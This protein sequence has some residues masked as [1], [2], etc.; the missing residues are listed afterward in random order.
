[1][2]TG[3]SHYVLPWEVSQNFNILICSHTWADLI[4]LS[5]YNNTKSIINVGLGQGKTAYAP[6]FLN[7]KIPNLYILLHRN[8]SFAFDL[9]LERWEYIGGT[10]RRVV[11]ISGM[12]SNKLE[13]AGRIE[14]DQRF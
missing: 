14:P 5:Q 7:S 6:F 9:D 1:M 4:H 8:Y 3:L 11:T 10:R 12:L 2:Q 13:I